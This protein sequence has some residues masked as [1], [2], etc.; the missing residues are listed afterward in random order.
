MQFSTYLIFF[1]IITLGSAF[2]HILPTME[3]FLHNIKQ[4]EN[5]SNY[6]ALTLIACVN[7]GRARKKATS[8]WMW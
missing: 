4:V 3:C 7:M 6:T 1:P 5:S 2:L 8:A